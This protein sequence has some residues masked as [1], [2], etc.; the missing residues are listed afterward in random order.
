M[1]KKATSTASKPVKAKAAK[2]SEHAAKPK[3]EMTVYQQFQK[4]NLTNSIYNT[5]TQQ[6][7]MKKG[8][9]DY[10]VLKKYGLL[11]KTNTGLY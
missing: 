6:E 11:G 8:A 3:K 4:K 5:G 2:S 7:K 9:A 1:P 10:N